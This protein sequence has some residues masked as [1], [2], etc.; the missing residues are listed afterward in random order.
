MRDISAFRAGRVAAERSSECR[1]ARCAPDR[2]DLGAELLVAAKWAAQV[3]ELSF[4]PQDL[5]AQLVK[6]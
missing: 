6:L 1:S 5:L 3:V 4:K 2:G